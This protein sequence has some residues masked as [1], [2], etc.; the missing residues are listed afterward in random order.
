[1]SVGITFGSIGDLIAVSEIAWSLS[2]ALKDSRGSV[3]EYRCLEKEL[4]T[5]SEAFRLV[6]QFRCLC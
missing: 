1:M 3:K 4:G 6:S 5:F 2:K